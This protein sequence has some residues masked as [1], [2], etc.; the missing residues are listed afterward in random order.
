MRAK[1]K[2]CHGCGEMRIIWRNDSGNR[3]CQPCWN[4][5]STLSAGVAKY[6][7]KKKQ[8]PIAPRSPKRAKQEREYSKER[9]IFLLANPNC[10]AKLPNQCTIS[11]TDVHHTKGREGW[12]LLAVAFWI[13]VC[14][15]CHTWIE[16]HP[17][18]AKQLG[19]SL[20]RLSNE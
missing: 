8:K 14:R 9:K 1:L 3:Y 6:R 17:E 4:Y 10:K 2:L 18:Q 13:P 11:A 7:T 19:L 5:K 15:G 12:L 20:N 16:E